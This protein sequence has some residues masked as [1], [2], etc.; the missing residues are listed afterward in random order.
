MQPTITIEYRYILDSVLLTINFKID[1]VQNRYESR[2]YNGGMFNNIWYP[3]TTAPDGSSI[4]KM[5]TT[6]EL[7]DIPEIAKLVIYNMD[8]IE[9]NYNE[10]RTR[11]NT[12]GVTKHIIT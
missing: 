11:L 4:H 10:L 1:N 3:Y 2:R 9:S 7:I 5:I 6:A 12:L 8:W